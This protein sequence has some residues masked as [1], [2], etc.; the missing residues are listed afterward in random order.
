MAVALVLWSRPPIDDDGARTKGGDVTLALIVRHGDGRTERVL[1]GG[2]RLRPGEAIRFELST[3]RAG[4]V[5]VVGID[6]ARAV[7]AYAPATGA[8]PALAAGRAQLLDG[9]VVLDETL[10]AE[11]IVAAVCAAPRPIDEL[12]A[13]ARRALARAG[14]DPRRV[15]T[16]GSGCDEAV[17][18][19]EKVRQ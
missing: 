14:G 1:P 13:A 15:E 19:I 12:V 18:T 4:Y 2:A 10:G 5:G 3:R 16:I 6:A 7:T 11:R 8:L 17:F 9:S